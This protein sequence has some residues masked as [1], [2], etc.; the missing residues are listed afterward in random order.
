MNLPPEAGDFGRYLS[1]VHL[2][3]TRG[4][5]RIPRLGNAIALARAAVG[6]T[7]W[8]NERITLGPKDVLVVDE[9]GMVDTQSMAKLIAHCERTGSKLILVGDSGQLQPVS[10]GGPFRHLNLMAVGNTF[11]AI[12]ADGHAYIYQVVKNT[13][14]VPTPKLLLDLVVQS[15]PVTM[16]LVAC[17]PV[18][19]TK[20]R[21][22]VTA[23]LVDVE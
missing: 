10:V 5:R 18:G 3:S 17:H 1:L 9:A 16:T 20:Y 19:S 4:P 8:K 15:G 22:V 11:A 12:G 6:K 14:I 2:S 21:I 23:R 13:V 7:T